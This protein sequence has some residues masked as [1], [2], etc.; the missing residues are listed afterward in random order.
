MLSSLSGTEIQPISRGL[1][2]AVLAISCRTRAVKTEEIATEE[3]FA[4]IGCGCSSDIIR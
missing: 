3:T 1:S 4:V 2:S